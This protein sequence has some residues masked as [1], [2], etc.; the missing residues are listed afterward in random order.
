VVVSVRAGATVDVTVDVKASGWGTSQ[1][2]FV[3]SCEPQYSDA[4]STILIR[5]KPGN[6]F[7]FGWQN[8]TAKIEVRMPPGMGLDVSSG[9]GDC[10]LT[11]DTEGSPVRYSTGSGDISISG[12]CKSLITESGSG[13]VKATL[14]KEAEKA[15]LSAGSGDIQVS[16]AIQDLSVETGS[17]SVGV[18]LSGPAAKVSLHTGSGDVDL[19]GA[20]RELTAHSGSG[21]IEAEGLV[22]G[23]QIESSSGDV[24]ARWSESPRGEKI[25]VDTSSGSVH[26]SFPAGAAFS[27][28]L[29]T[30]SGDIRCDFPGTLRGKRE[31]SFALAGP[32][33]SAELTVDTSSGDIQIIAAK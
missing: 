26:L 18:K 13:N 4:G 22:G 27:G 17:G 28:R 2:E 24:T 10:S 33:G 1:Q 31:G 15:E 30:N 25:S 16:G 8:L 7:S 6:H 29:D 11:G 5:S 23:A 12:A 14:T 20:A 19:K 21:L 9:S 32:A 3:K